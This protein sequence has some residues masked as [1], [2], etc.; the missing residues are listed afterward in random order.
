MLSIKLMSTQCFPAK[1]FWF[2]TLSE[3]SHNNNNKQQKKL[4]PLEKTK[5]CGGMV[6]IWNQDLLSISSAPFSTLKLQYWTELVAAAELFKA[7]LHFWLKLLN[8]LSNGL[9]RD[10]I[11]LLR[12]GH[13]I[14]FLFEGGG[15]RFL[16]Y[17]FKLG[18]LLIVK[19]ALVEFLS[20]LDSY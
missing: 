20:Q 16:L 12:M 9:H 3:I 5:F 19:K 11:G 7:F 13:G 18:S 10:I 14:I 8:L 17:R 2:F 4:S 15:W 1:Y 6:S